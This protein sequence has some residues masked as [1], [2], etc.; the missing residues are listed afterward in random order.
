MAVVIHMAKVIPKLP[1]NVALAFV[2]LKAWAEENGYRV[3][4]V[5]DKP[6]R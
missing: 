1:R 3:I 4:L 6:V 5:R 2:T